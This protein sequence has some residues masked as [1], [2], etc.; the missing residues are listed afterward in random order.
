MSQPV[1][2]SCNY[3]KAGFENACQTVKKWGSR[4]VTAIKSGFTSSISKIYECARSCLKAIGNF[5]SIGWE[6][7]TQLA[8]DY[9]LPITLIVIVAAIIILVREHKFFNF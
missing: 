1:Q 6:R 7:G 9:P 2:G 3:F 8:K 5:F 4:A